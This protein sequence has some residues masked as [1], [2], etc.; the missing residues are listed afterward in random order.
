MAIVVLLMT[1]VVAFGLSE[2]ADLFPE[3][4]WGWIHGGNWLLWATVLALVSWGMKG[5]DTR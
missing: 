1:I 3:V 5:E 4:L 2:F